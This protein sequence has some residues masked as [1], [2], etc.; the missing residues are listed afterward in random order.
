MR[1]AR[2]TLTR[3]AFL[4][5]RPTSLLGGHVTIWLN[6]SI[7]M[8]FRII[9]GLSIRFPQSDVRN[10]H[11]LLLSPWPESRSPSSRYGRGWPSTP[12]R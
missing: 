7:S 2:T 12:T 6:E 1:L 9:D 8:Q 11:A 5:T 4:N 3:N 10:D